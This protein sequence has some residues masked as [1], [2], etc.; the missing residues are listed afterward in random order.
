MSYDISDRWNSNERDCAYCGASLHPYAVGVFPLAYKPCSTC[1]STPATEARPVV[2]A[3]ALRAK[4]V[5]ARVLL[6]EAIEDEKRR[7]ETAN[8][9]TMDMEA[10]RT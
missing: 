1:E 3:V 5:A 2:D 10:N 9:I 6:R 8:A 7:C 4:A